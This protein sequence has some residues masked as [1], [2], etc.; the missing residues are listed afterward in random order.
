ME[1]GRLT[2][3]FRGLDDAELRQMAKYVRSPLFNRKTTIIRL[4][5]YLRKKKGLVSDSREVFSIVFPREEFSAQKLHYVNS[6]LLEHVESFLAWRNFTENPS[7]GCLHLMNIFRRKKMEKPFIRAKKR[8]KR[9]MEESVLRNGSFLEQYYKMEQEVIAEQLD[10]E[11]KTDLDFQSLSDMQDAYFMA[12]KLKIACSMLS[13]QT[14]ARKEY[15]FGLT[16]S[17]LSKIESEGKYLEYP[18]IAIYF[19]AFKCLSDESDEEAFTALK[20]EI[21][22]NISCFSSNEKKEIYFLATNFC[23]KK[24]NSGFQPYL[25]EAFYMYKSGLKND[26]LS[27][28]GLLSRWT[29]NNIIVLGLKLKEF[30]WVEGFIHEYKSFL[31]EKIRAD[32][33]HFNLAKFYFEKKEFGKAMPLLVQT[34]YDDLL[35]I[36]GAKTMLAKMYFET[37]EWDALHHLLESFKVFIQ[38]KDNIGYHGENYLNIIRFIKKI[39]LTDLS[40]KKKKT[41]LATEIKNTKILTEKDWLLE[42]LRN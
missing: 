28:D 12:E 42:Q 9:I 23:I 33:F 24:L 1:Q 8:M 2:Q 31:E 34:H 32:S 26:A 41:N 29:Y 19:Y 20:K 25:R 30:D 22:K 11:R 27:S 3:L 13:Y 4:F 21:R 14:V 38:R 15:D 17:I 39:S 5:D 37:G 18:A 36:L 16:N 40:D 35:H 7:E 10:K 6:A